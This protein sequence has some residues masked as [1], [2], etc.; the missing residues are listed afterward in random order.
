MNREFHI[1]LYYISSNDYFNKIFKYWLLF[2]YET[3][4]FDL[5][6]ALRA[7]MKILIDKYF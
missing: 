5:C 4:F 3:I 7:N 1:D 2:L 6:Q